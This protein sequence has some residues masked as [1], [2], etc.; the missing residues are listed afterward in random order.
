MARN[1]T[2]ESILT[3]FRLDAKL[4]SSSALNAQNE[5]RQIHLI[6]REQ[7]RLWE[8]TDWAHLR[9]ERFIPLQAGQRFYD[10]SSALNEA[11]AAKNDL[12]IDR[13]EKM[14]VKDGGEWCPLYNGIG[15]AEYV[16]HDSALDERASPAC[17]WR[18]YEGEQ[19]E[20][21]PVPEVDA[22]AEQEGYLRVTGIRDLR[23]FVEMSDRADLDGQLI[24]AYAA[25]QYLAAKKAADTEMVLAKAQKLY[26][27][28]TANLKKRKSF[29]LF[30]VGG[31][32]RAQRRPMI[33]RYKA[34]D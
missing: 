32:R 5:E 4:A 7:K 28:L 30:G 2:L 18:I 33:T 6:Q 16:A 29:Q 15:A 11:G 10:L 20:I 9:V 17:A 22:T 14:D 24:S 23:P 34:P 19:L 21:W 27:R 26:A 25:G 1:E 12:S 31:S 13:I 8:E 3:D